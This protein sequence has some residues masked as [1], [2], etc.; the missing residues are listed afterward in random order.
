MSKN[1]KE[2][3]GELAVIQKNQMSSD[4]LIKARIAKSEGVINS[5]ASVYEN[6]DI[7]ISNIE[8]R[9]DNLE[10]NEEITDEQV[11]TIQARIKKRVSNVLDYPN[12]E[13]EKYYQ[14]F[15]SNIYA[16]LRHSYSLGSRTATTKK[17]HYDTVMRG[18]EAWHP[19]IQELKARKDKRDK[20]GQ[21]GN[22]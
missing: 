22:S 14:T 1:L 3:I 8:N 19:N 5:L 9:M 20:S 12:G 17:K 13:S 4:E 18:I 11:R 15:I 2:M 7:Q 6:H 10:L 16:N 21:E